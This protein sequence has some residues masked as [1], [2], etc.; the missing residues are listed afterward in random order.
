MLSSFWQSLLH[1]RRPSVSVEK[2]VAVLRPHETGASLSVHHT[3]VSVTFGFVSVPG[4]GE[5]PSRAGGCDLC[6]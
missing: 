1:Y 4:N 2:G 3:P 6:D 5:F